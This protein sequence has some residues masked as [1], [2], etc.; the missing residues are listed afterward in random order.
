MNSKDGVCWNTLYIKYIYI[1]Y[2]IVGK[3]YHSLPTHSHITTIKLDIVGQG[4]LHYT[5]Q[6]L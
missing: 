4:T 6:M 2:N 5:T 3:Q 1:W